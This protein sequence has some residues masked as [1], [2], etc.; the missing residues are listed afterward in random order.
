MSREGYITIMITILGVVVGVFAL[1]LGAMAF[2]GYGAIIEG[3]KK[4]AEDCATEITNSRI[5]EIAKKAATEYME[6]YIKDE[7]WEENLT[8]ALEESKTS[9][10]ASNMV[11]NPYPGEE[12]PNGGTG[13]EADGRPDHP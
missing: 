7:R 2:I 5:E 6:K 4:K 8:K 9:A 11:G 12:D 1:I 10:E 13:K 3:A